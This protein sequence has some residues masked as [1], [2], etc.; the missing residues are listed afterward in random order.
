M[1][2]AVDAVRQGVLKYRAAAPQFNVPAAT[3]FRRIKSEK[4]SNLAAKK[5][6][7]MACAAAEVTDR[8][9]PP[10][11]DVNRGVENITSKTA[12]DEQGPSSSDQQNVSVAQEED[13][14]NRT[15]NILTKAI[16]TYP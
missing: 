1:K 4:D 12:D 3:L 10:Q 14:S 5:G 7:E 8:P 11:N 9:I 6:L 13:N 15:S 2:N 16:S